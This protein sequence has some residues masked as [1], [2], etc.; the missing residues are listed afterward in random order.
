MTNETITIKELKENIW[1]RLELH[2]TEIHNIFEV[3]KP[4]NY[5]YV[6]TNVFEWLS[7]YEIVDT[8]FLV[9][10]YSDEEDFTSID[11]IEFEIVYHDNSYNWG[12]NSNIDI[13]FKGLV[14]NHD[15]MYLLVKFHIGTDIRAG[16]TNSIMLDLNAYAYNNASENFFLTMFDSLHENSITGYVEINGIEYSIN[17][18]IEREELE[19]Y[20]HTTD[21]SIEVYDAIYCWNE[22]E[23]DFNNACID[24]VKEYIDKLN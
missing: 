4:K 21:E 10:R 17:G 8:D 9:D 2:A 16:Y 13:D 22:T 3:A 11:N 23:E 14:D 5:N 7:R 12:G 24:L 20:N 19:I 6:G 15:N 18:H 1:E